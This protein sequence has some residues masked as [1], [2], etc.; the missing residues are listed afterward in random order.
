MTPGMAMGEKRS[1][2]EIALSPESAA[3]REIQTAP[4]IRELPEFEVRMVGKVD[5]DETRVGS[6]TA[7]VPGRIEHLYIDFTGIRVAK[8]DHMVDLYSPDLLIAQEE[9]LQALKA[10]NKANLEAVRGKLRLWGLTDDQISEIEKRGTASDRITIYSPLSG[11]VIKKNAVE[12]MYIDTGTDIYTIADLSQVWIMLDA[13]ESDLAWIRYGQ[14][15]EFQAE[16]YPGDIF[17]GR[18][19]F[20][21]PTL[22]DMTRTVKVRVD[23]PNQDGRLKPEMFVHGIVRAKVSAGG[24]VVDPDLASKY[25]CRMHP[26]VIEDNPGKCRF[27]GM[28][29]V[30]IEELE[31]VKSK[32]EAPLLIPATAPLITGK[33]AVV[34]IAEMDE[35][36]RLTGKFTGREILLGSRVHVVK[37]QVPGKESAGTE[38]P[39]G[40]A[41]GDYYI[42]RNGLNEGENVV[43]Y[44]NFAIDSA[45]Q[46]QAGPSMMSPGGG[47]M[48]GMHHGGMKMPATPGGGGATMPMAP[49]EFM[50]ALDPVYTAYFKVHAALVADN[51]DDARKGYE[52]LGKAIAAV[53][54]SSL[55]GQLVLRWNDL[56]MRLSNSSSEGSRDKTLDD[57]RDTFTTFSDEIIQLER[58]FSHGG[59]KPHYIMYSR[60]AFGG[61][62]AS[63]LQE[64]DVVQN[65]YLTGAKHPSDVLQERLTP[66]YGA[67][68]GAPKEGGKPAEPP[69]KPAE[70]P[71]AFKKQMAELLDSYLAIH[72]ALVKNDKEA[73]AKAAAAFADALKKVDMGLL[74]DD[75]AMMAWMDAEKKLHAAMD[76][77]TKA[78]NIDKQR[79][80]FAGLSA[81]MAESLVKFGYA[82]ATPVT[83]FNCSMAH[84]NWLQEGEEVSNPYYGPGE[85]LR[86]GDK[87]R[88]LPATA[89]EGN[90]P[91]HRHGD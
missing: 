77:L 61:E 36:G 13:Y 49:H 42:V 62:G 4:V 33:R 38:T 1:L 84:A 39:T 72:G 2:R 19:A 78:D 35:Q 9:L 21:S 31:L 26:Q 87:V 23:V 76:A 70:T 27:C 46:I 64:T 53:D 57:A 89:P 8:G 52:E 86:C 24:A 54:S 83:E 30:K 71:L 66:M 47:G 41:P 79:A 74:K 63:W 44:G 58:W 67:A 90:Q 73:A 43:T 15:V 37:D 40:P 60:D 10:Q 69:A 18:I 48:A 3:L 17:T 11:V 75:A 22:N 12:G 28:P 56:N 14:N 5:F 68:E 85:N 91:E 55:T 7:R 50:I 6:I 34:Y 20:I 82:R 81:A 88:S 16:A 51:L 32:G 45:V 59:D 65:P 25:T 80:A 29:L